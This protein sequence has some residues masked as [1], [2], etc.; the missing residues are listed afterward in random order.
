MIICLLDILTT[1]AVSRVICYDCLFF[2]LVDFRIVDLELDEFQNK[3][4][5]IQTKDSEQGLL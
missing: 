2:L 5:L 3:I 1:K 4:L